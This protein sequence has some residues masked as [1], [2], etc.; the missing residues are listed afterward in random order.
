MNLK[1]EEKLLKIKVWES[2]KNIEENYSHNPPLYS[3]F[4]N[5][6]R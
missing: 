4:W 2:M 5:Q 3:E 6:I 1:L